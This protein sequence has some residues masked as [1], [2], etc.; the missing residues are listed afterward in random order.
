MEEK[1]VVAPTGHSKRPRNESTGMGRDVRCRREGPTV[2]TLPDDCLWAIIGLLAPRDVAALARTSRRMGEAT[3]G[4]PVWFYRYVAASE[5]ARSTIGTPFPRFILGYAHA[6]RPCLG[7]APWA[8]RFRD[9][10]RRVHLSIYLVD[11]NDS[12]AAVLARRGSAPRTDAEGRPITSA[13]LKAAVCLR[14]YECDSRRLTLTVAA[15]LNISPFRFDLWRVTKGANDGAEPMGTDDDDGAMMLP[16]PSSRSDAVPITVDRRLTT[17]GA[18]CRLSP[19]VPAWTLLGDDG[20]VSGDESSFDATHLAVGV[21]PVSHG[22][23]YDERLSV[24]APL[25]SLVDP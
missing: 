24:A 20:G 7:G 17:S 15:V 1:A 12:A 13:P 5:S 3:S 10:A 16:P 25:P 21:I 6:F 9:A 14:R 11:W 8:H 4:E 22:A 2:E 18:R 23:L 19:S